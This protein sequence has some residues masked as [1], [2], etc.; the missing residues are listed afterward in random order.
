MTI[1]TSNDTLPPDPDGIN[2]E[3]TDWAGIAIDAFE[4]A[5]GTDREDVL[6]D[7]LTDLMHWAD[8]HRFD[9]EAAFW[10]AEDHYREETRPVDD[11][12]PAEPATK[13]T[14]ITQPKRN[15]L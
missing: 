10:R 7:L 6:C 1:Q 14:P 8:R 13:R 2:D 9:F 3:R 11:H 12:P 15:S 5:T 4:A